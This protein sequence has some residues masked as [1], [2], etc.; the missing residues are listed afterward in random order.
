[1]RSGVWS[2]PIYHL[3]TFPPPFSGSGE[4]HQNASRERSFASLRGRGEEQV[5]AQ[6]PCT[7]PQLLLYGR[8]MPGLLQDHHRLQPRTD[9][10]SLRGLRHRPVSTHRWKGEANGRLLLQE[11]ATLKNPCLST[12][13]G[14]SF[15]IL[16]KIHDKK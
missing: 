3:A 2:D 11:E 13:A 14:L 5:Q 12:G 1:M 10:R 15:F 7:A 9:C 6:A 16:T 4:Q 8:E